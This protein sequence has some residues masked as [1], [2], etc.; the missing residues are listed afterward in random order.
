MAWTDLAFSF[1]SLLTSTKMTQLDANFDAMAAGDSGAPNIAFA[2]LI[3]D[4]KERI[5]KA[6]ISLDGTGTPAANDSYNVTSITDNGTGNYTLVWDTDFANANYCA[7]VGGAK[8]ASYDIG[9]SGYFIVVDAGNK[10]VGSLVIRTTH[11]PASN[12]SDAGVFDMKEINVIAIG[13]Q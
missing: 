6:W 8:A 2:A 4:L 10:A 1:G 3:A 9:S 5:N 11:F 12:S 13:D 7:V